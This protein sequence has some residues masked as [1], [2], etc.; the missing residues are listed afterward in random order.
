MPWK[1]YDSTV[2]DI[3]Q[4]GPQTKVFRLEIEGEEPWTFTAGQFITADLPIHE[5]RLRRWRSYSIAN[6][7][8]STRVI[9]LCIV[10]LE[11]GLASEYLFNKVRLGSSIRFKGP[12]G[13]FILPEKLQSEIV[14]VCTGTG[15]APFRSMLLDL[16]RR[17]E[18][19][20]PVHLIF[21]TRTK[22]NILYRAEFENLEK[23]EKN[24]TYS[25]ALSRDED[26][27]G[28]KGYV[29]QIYMSAYSSP[30]PNRIFYL[31]GW[32]MMID[33][34]VNNLWQVLGYER[35]QIKYELYG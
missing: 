35:S 16:S 22:E 26:W 18:F 19:Q 29:H 7:P 6:P 25:I 10:Y 34:A 33:E 11:G 31:C 1:W 13:T 30:Q 8:D 32:S 5:K 15:V 12:S 3:E 14:M 2:I 28:W 20:Q 17:G 21:G 9:E 27:V 24:F 4:I 23:E